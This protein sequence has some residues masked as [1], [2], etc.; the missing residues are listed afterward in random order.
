MVRI[1][2]VVRIILLVI[3]ALAG[4]GIVSVYP[5]FLIGKFFCHRYFDRWGEKLVDL[6]KRGLLSKTY[7]AG[8]QDVLTDEAMKNA[9]ALITNGDSA[10][11]PSHDQPVQVVDGI[12]LDDYP[13]LSIINRLREVRTYSNTIEIVDRRDRMIANIRTDHYRARIDEFPATLIEALL[14]AEDKNFMTN[15][16]GFEFD[17][18]VRAALRAAFESLLSC[19]KVPPRGTSTI[20]QQVAKLFISRLDEQGFRRVTRTIDRK[21]R[22]LQIAVALRKMFPPGDILEVYCNHCV[23]SDYGMIG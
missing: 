13:S 17:S 19:K 20:T 16:Y 3:A 18:F 12:V 6:E 21:I 8:W 5:A 22:E 7:G 23:T 1:P 10:A 2:R 11:A 15:R 4:L 14:A 9:A